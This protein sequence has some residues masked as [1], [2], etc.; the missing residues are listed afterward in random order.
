LSPPRKRRS[1]NASV[2]FSEVD[3]S[4]SLSNKAS[5]RQAAQ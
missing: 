1:R 5:R 3:C 2:K 4:A